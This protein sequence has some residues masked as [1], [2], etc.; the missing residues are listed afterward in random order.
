MDPIL[1]VGFSQNS[2]KKSINNLFTTEQ[3]TIMDFAN[4]ADPASLTKAASSANKILVLASLPENTIAKELA[5]ASESDSLEKTFQ[6][7]VQKWTDQSQQLIE[8]VLE[9]REK[10]FVIAEELLQELDG[11]TIQQLENFFSCKISESEISYEAPIPAYQLIASAL[12]GEGHF[13]FD[14][15]EELSA[16]SN[17]GQSIEEHHSRTITLAE[18]TI[19]RK[20]Q[21]YSQ[22]SELH[23]TNKRV[24]A[25]F[26]QVSS[27]NELALLQIQQLQEELEQVVVAKQKL[28]ATVLEQ[29][30]SEELLQLQV[31]QL[32]EELEQTYMALSQSNKEAAALKSEL[33]VLQ[34]NLKTNVDNE[35]KEQ[36]QAKR[37]E[38]ESAQLDIESENE[39]L[40]LQVHQLQEE[41]E[42]YYLKA[43]EAES[44]N[45][46]LEHLQYSTDVPP[47]TVELLRA[48]SSPLSS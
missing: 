37:S 36:W 41:L 45:E 14:N 19:A 39:L 17:V 26:T 4:D 10:C 34:S 24:E 40:L 1:V 5:S 46:Q 8:L 20:K 30:S 22:I 35:E 48:L 18:K 15:Y 6:T 32:Q 13:I 25:D 7:S 3:L 21:F 44:K 38:L 23:G 11:N 47:T 12:L 2:W 43:K 33:S 31:Q 9:N 27:E 16:L 42:H 28:D 29:E